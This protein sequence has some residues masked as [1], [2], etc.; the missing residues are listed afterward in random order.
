VDSF[1]AP[2][3]E[4]VTGVFI[5]APRIVRTGPAVEVLLRHD[6]EPVLVRQGRVVAA[7][8]HPE[9]SGGLAALGIE[10][11]GG[12]PMPCQH[13]HCNCEDASIRVGSESFCS[14]ECASATS[15]GE[16]E[17]SCG[18]PECGGRGPAE[19]SSRAKTEARPPAE[20]SPRRAR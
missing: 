18:H 1:E 10:W 2:L 9:L 8:F 11:I 16:F 6:G 15:R 17:C 3:A 7:T 20:K 14:R 4:G 13:D 19:T 12:Q 5:R